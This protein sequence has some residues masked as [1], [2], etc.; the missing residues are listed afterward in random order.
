MPTILVLTEE[1]L[2]ESDVKKILHLH[3]DPEARFEVLVPADTERNV[4]TDI[5][6][7]LSLFE[8]HKAWDSLTHRTDAQTAR[9]EADTA[10]NTS[11]D[12]FSAVGAEASGSVIADDPL[13]ALTQAVNNLRADELIVVTRPHAVEDTFHQDWASRA[14]EEL[15][16]PV[17]HFYSGTD[18][19]G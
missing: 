4:I 15:G 5:I 17:L 19:V 6:D 12:R 16:V 11:L 9:S 7:H 18:F 10:L 2:R 1:A 3:D 13:P 8:M 14:R